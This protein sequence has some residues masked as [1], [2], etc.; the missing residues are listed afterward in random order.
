M[1]VPPCD[2]SAEWMIIVAKW[3]W[4]EASD[5]ETEG[6]GSNIFVRLSGN[7]NGGNAATKRLEAAM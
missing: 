7:Q 4:Q 2:R 3:F 1:S 5:S 6:L